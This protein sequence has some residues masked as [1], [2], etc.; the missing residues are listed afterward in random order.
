MTAM[1]GTRSIRKG[2]PLGLNDERLLMSQQYLN[3]VYFSCSDFETNNKVSI[4]FIMAA[5]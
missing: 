5:F 1:K 3:L 2:I 4:K